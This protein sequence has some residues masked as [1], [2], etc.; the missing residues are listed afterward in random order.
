MALGGVATGNI[1]AQDAPKPMMSESP[2]G[3]SSIF[4]ATEMKIGTKSAAL[5]VLLVNEELHRVYQCLTRPRLCKD[6]T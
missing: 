4:S 3:S 5:A 6:N 1:K 2:N